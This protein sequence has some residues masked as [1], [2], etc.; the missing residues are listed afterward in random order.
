MKKISI[1]GSTGSIGTQSLDVIRRSPED[2]SVTALS[3]AR[4]VMELA[5]Q[6]EEFHPL[7]AVTADQEGAET[8]EKILKTRGISGTQVLYGAEG[9][10][11]ACEMSEADTVIN[12]LMGMRGLV[13]TYHAIKAG[14]TLAFA[15]KETLVVGGELIMSMVENSGGALLPIDSEHSAIFQCL[16][17]NE[18]NPIDRILLTCSG[19]PFRSYSFEQ[20]QNVTKAQAL[21]HP[22]WNMGQKITI[23]S[24]TLV[25]KCLEVIEAK[26]L[27]GVEPK[28]IQVLIHP[29]S[30]IHSAVQFKDH[31]IMAQLGNPD[32]RIPISYALSYPKR[33]SN[34]FE[35]LD[36]FSLTDG[37]T[38]EKP[39]TT[40]FRTL[41]YAYDVLRVGGSAPIALNAANEELVAAFLEEKIR[42]CDIQNGISDILEFHKLQKNMGLEDI[43]EIERQVREETKQLIEK[44]RKEN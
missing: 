26:W 12:S 30:I 8:L 23:D 33:I 41:Q 13:P 15:N 35:S 37:L 21:N 31:S 27:F 2:Y 28:Q 6:I 42:F 3:C 34:D 32:M 11:A 36:F 40:T 5:D 1:L 18:E 10:V 17:G 9:L 29:Q 7:L 43:L 20:L 39:D 44:Y 25:N 4:R 14:K 22:K 16:Q 19:G 38:F 24:A